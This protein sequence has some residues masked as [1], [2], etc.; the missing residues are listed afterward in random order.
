MKEKTVTETGLEL[1]ARDGT[2]PTAPGVLAVFQRDTERR[3]PYRIDRPRSFGR[4]D[5]ADI[6]IDDRAV[7][8]EHAVFEPDPGGILVT[9]LN[10]HNGTFIDGIRVVDKRSFAPYGSVVRLAKTALFVM[11]D[12]VPFEVTEY[13]PYPALVGGPALDQARARIATV[14]EEP[15]PVLVEGETGTGKE[16]VAQILHAA[17]RREGHL[18]DLNCAALAPELVESELFGHARGSFSG[19]QT[20]RAGL[21]R[22]AHRG[23]LFLDE[24]G[25]LPPAVQAKLLRVIETNSVRS[26]GEDSPTPVDVRVVAATNRDLDA[27]VEAGEFRGDLL[28]RIAAT[29]IQLPP[30]TERREDIPAL[31]AHFIRGERIGIDVGAAELLLLRDWP[32]NVRELRNAVLTAA[33]TAR[34]AERDVIRA[35]DVQAV[36]PQKRASSGESDLKTRIT[37]ALANC[38]GNVTRAARDLGMARSG[39]YEA[40]RRLRVNPAAF[41]RR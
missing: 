23:T 15:T 27:M 32:G 10:S 8:R 39:L 1:P 24:I 5:E 20:T 31:C 38:D 34:K 12:V 2:R 6:T 40:L 14:A 37:Q 13:N 17:S 11:D 26:V 9:D 3:V 22:A 28:H 36:A 16:V 18:V 7:S 21:F 4:G 33:A 35:E 41:R 19:S 29:R 25:E 30:L